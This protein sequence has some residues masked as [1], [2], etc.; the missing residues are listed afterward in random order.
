M[1]PA[2]NFFELW[3]LPRLHPG[4]PTKSLRLENENFW[5]LPSVLWEY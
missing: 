5:S 1:T 4:D 2:G 3:D